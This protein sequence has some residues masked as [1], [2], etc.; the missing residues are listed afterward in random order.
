MGYQV[1]EDRPAL[2]HGVERWAGYGVPAICDFPTCETKI[3]RGMA[4]RCEEYTVYRYF[5]EE[6]EQ[7][8]EEEH[9]DEEREEQEE[10]CEMHFCDEHS[11]HDTHKDSTPKPDTAEWEAWML[12][13]ESWEQWRSQNPDKVRALRAR[14]ALA[15]TAGAPVVDAPSGGEASHEQA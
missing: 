7:V 2:D 8:S 4:Y 5:D 10:G 13:D 15:T 11:N 1:Y 3:D 14:A 12:T 9:W 6:G